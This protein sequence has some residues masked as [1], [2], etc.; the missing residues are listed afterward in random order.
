M[1]KYELK[2]QYFDEWMI[3]WRK[4][5][6][7]SDWEIEKNRQWWRRFNMVFS[8][9]ILSGLCVCTAGTATIRRQYGLP[10]FFD[11]GFDGQIKSNILRT[12]TSRWRY[13][14]QG[15]G[16]LLITGVPTYIA[17]VFMEHRSERRRMNQYLRQNTVFGEQ[18]RRFQKTGKIEE[19]LPVNIKATLPASQQ[20]IYNY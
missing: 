17:F 5:Q 16:R 11:V 8:G 1:T 10:H 19:Y 6:T 3:R 14:P 4:F 7:E 15:Y 13:T 9:T 18:M 12:L 20:A 2:L